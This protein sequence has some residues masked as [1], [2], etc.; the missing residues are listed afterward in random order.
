MAPSHACAAQAR[1]LLLVCGGLLTAAAPQPG[2]ESSPVPASQVPA[3]TVVPVVWAGNSFGLGGHNVTTK[4]VRAPSSPQVSPR[5]RDS[6]LV[7][8]STAAST[9]AADK[10]GRA[11]TTG[12]EMLEPW[13]TQVSAISPKKIVWSLEGTEVLEEGTRQ[14][15]IVGSIL[16]PGLDPLELTP[17]VRAAFERAFVAGLPHVAVGGVRA[18]R[19]FAISNDTAGVMIPPDRRLSEAVQHSLNKHAGALEVEF[20]VAVAPDA[21]ATGLD[22]VEARLILLSMGGKTAERF[23]A[24]LTAALAAAGAALPTGTRTCIGEPQQLGPLDRRG[25]VLGALY[26][27]EA[28]EEGVQAALAA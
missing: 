21:P 7:V 8:S 24:E 19:V 16:V 26:D 14:G 11:A 23:D 28:E 1:T 6:T 12:L 22:Q 3:G 4:L 2:S 15:R 27:S 18:L 10:G 17:S 25:R 5:A 9:S 13:L 20:N